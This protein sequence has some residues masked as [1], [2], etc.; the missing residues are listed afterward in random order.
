MTV[1]VYSNGWATESD[2]WIDDASK[3]YIA[4]AL[5][6]ALRGDD[7]RWDSGATAQVTAQGVEVVGNVSA[8]TVYVLMASAGFEV[9]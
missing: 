1:K 8:D 7:P 5:A 6:D 9:E 2:V 3:G 4:D